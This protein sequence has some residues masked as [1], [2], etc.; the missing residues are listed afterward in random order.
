MNAN[1]K[2]LAACEKADRAIDL[3][4]FH[5]GSAEKLEGATQPVVILNGSDFEE[6]LEA[7]RDIRP[8]VVSARA[9]GGS[10]GQS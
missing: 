7:L 2:L 8:A 9:A 5:E 6:I 10:E 4:E 3:L 1:A